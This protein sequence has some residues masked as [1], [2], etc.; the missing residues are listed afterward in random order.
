MI[1]LPE[2][3]TADPPTAQVEVLAVSVGGAEFGLPVERVTG[4]IRVPTLTRIPFPPPS[5]IGVVSVRGTLVPVL[6]LGD[7]LLGRAA[8]RDGRVVLVEEAGSTQQMGLLVDAVIGLMSGAPR[9]GELPPEIEAS[10]PRG[11]VAGIL[12]SDS[13]RLITLLELEP[14]LAV[15]APTDK[16]QR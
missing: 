16:E 13:E 8:D 12:A 4:V 1:E 14:V 9:E 15:G 7:R 10:L 11:W 3:D 2:Q 6:D 5:I